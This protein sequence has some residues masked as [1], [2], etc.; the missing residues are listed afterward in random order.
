LAP[1]AVRALGVEPASGT[2]SV[3]VSTGSPDSAVA[4]F[5]KIVA[6]ALRP[7]AGEP[8]A[9][10]AI[11][12]LERPN[13]EI[14]MELPLVA[15]R[16]AAEQIVEHVAQRLTAVASA[17]FA[18]LATLVGREALKL[19]AVEFVAGTAEPTP[20]GHEV[21]AALAEALSL[22]TV[23][24]IQVQPNEGTALDRAALARAQ[25]LLH[26]TLA[27]ARAERAATAIDFASPRVQDVLAEFAGERL[28]AAALEEVDATLPFDA[29]APPGAPERVEHYRALFEAL[30]D[31]EPI[32]DAALRR[33]ASFR[34]RTVER[35]L[36]EL[37]VAGS[38]IIELGAGLSA[39]DGLLAVLPLA[40]EPAPVS[41]ER[42]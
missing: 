25:V 20:R 14:A 32:A 30:A 24:G 4:G 8:T 21:I 22:R 15:E 16:G 28:S 38:Q 29:A 18:A 6:H 10:M 17:P 1:Y 11:A 9:A 37:G 2:V 39:S 3:E 41:D 40:L 42:P 5:A 19:S 31:R 33:L 27:T 23:I 7:A 34:A 36:G 26:V 13:G 12:L 35:R